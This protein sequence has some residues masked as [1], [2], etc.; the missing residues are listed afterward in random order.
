MLKSYEAYQR[1]QILTASREKLLLMLCDGIVRFTK[2]ASLACQEG[3][4]EE[5]GN[6]LVKAQA[7]LSQLKSDLN[8][9]TG[10]IA[11]NLELLYDY[12]YRRLIEANVKKDREIIEE[13]FRMAVELRDIWRGA[14]RSFQQVDSMHGKATV[15]E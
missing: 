7:I 13:V 3:K 4:I 15:G 5:T 10:D 11:G 1:N 14:V 2:N 6:N 12:M 8:L 9:D